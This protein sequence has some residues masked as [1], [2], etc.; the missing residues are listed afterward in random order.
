MGISLSSRQRRNRTMIRIAL[1]FLLVALAAGDI[2]RYREAVAEC[3]SVHQNSNCPFMKGASNGQKN[4][5]CQNLA[6]K[7]ASECPY[8]KSASSEQLSAICECSIVASK[9]PYMTSTRQMAEM[10]KEGVYK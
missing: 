4:K 7:Y 8:L 2:A 9:C 5:M 10:C 6:C 1:L 3:Q